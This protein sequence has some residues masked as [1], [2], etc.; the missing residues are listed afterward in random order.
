MSGARAQFIEHRPHPCLRGL[1]ARITGYDLTGFEP[2]THV[3]M[4]SANLT[5][6]LPLGRPITVSGPV[7][8]GGQNVLDVPRAFTGLTGGL[9]DVP[10]LIHHDGSQAGLQLDLTPAGARALLGLPSAELAG[11]VVALDDVLGRAGLLLAEEVSQTP[12]WAARFALVEARLRARAQPVPGSAQTWQAWRQLRAA[13]GG[14]TIEDVARSVHWS[15]RQLTHAFTAEFGHPPKVVA[16]L[17]RFQRAHDLLRAPRLRIADVA[18]ACGYADQAHLS[19]EF[20]RM[21][22]V[23]PRHWREVEVFAGAVAPRFTDDEA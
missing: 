21:A 8:D 18:A 1:V 10:V 12:T 23:S 3:G 19:R 15:R 9:H 20:S 4:P 13:G 11:R 16:R 22:G 5:L 14:L 17:M 7:R 2:G 6:I